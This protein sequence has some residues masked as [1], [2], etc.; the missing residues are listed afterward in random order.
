[1]G[2]GLQ[3]EREKGLRGTLSI[4]LEFL[5]SWQERLQPDCTV[6]ESFFFL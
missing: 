4:V 6:R 3:L 5:I 1:M 2:G